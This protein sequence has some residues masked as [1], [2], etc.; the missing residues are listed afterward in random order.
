MLR[1]TVEV[2]LW[3]TVLAIIFYPHQRI[4]RRTNRPTAAAILSCLLVV[5]VIVL[6]LTVLA[7]VIIEEAG[8]AGQY[9]QNNYVRLLDAGQPHMKFLGRFVNVDRFR[10]PEGFREALAAARRGGR[11]ADGRHRRQRAGEAAEDG[12]RR[13][14]DV[15]PVP[16]RRAC[17]RRSARCCRSTAR[18]RR[19]IFARTREVINAS[20]HGVMVIAAIQGFMGGLAFWVLGLPSPLLWGSI[21][22]LLSM[23]PLVGSTVVWIPTAAWLLITGQ[24]GKAA[25]AD[26]VGRRGDLVGRQLPARASSA[27]RRASTSCSCSSA[28]SAG[29]RSSASWGS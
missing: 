5:A 17:R 12:L 20:V 9:L 16:R 8:E 6:P 3:A 4:L 23:I 7:V 28:S 18:D 1:P 25:A 22:T 13:L 21:M 24:W 10:S 14:H 27:A 26:A 11:Q 29:C 15:L 19:Q 2:L